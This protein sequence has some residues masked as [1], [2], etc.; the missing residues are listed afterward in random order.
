MGYE[1][2]TILRGYKTNK[3]DIVQEFYLPVLKESVLYKRAVGFFSSTALIELSKGI[4]GLVK[5]GGKIRFIVSPLLSEEDIE[6]IQKGYEARTIIESALVREIKEPQSDSD[7][8]RL[9]WLSQLIANGV[10][11]IKVAFTPPHKAT[12]MYHEKI[13]VIY[14]GNGNLI[15]FTGSMNETINA[16]H[17]NYE[18]IVVFNSLVQEDK[19]RV[20]DLENDFDSLWASREENITV[21]EFPKVVRDRLVPYE[22]YRLS[23]HDNDHFEAEDAYELSPVVAGVPAIPKGVTLHEYQNDAISAW[24][25]NGMRG[26]F[27][28]ATGTGKTYTGLGAVVKAFE[29]NK[30]LAVII[31]AP[32][33]HL[34]DQWVEDIVK[35][36]MRPTI[37]YSASPQ[38]DWKRRLGND[39][40]DFELGCI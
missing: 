6:A 22:K 14:D 4:A 8:E 1:H 32:Y 27:D 5:N 29:L 17:N 30:R 39:V 16:F 9:G 10:L 40:L 21:L 28:M 26:I 3:N 2:L 37:G 11:E 7:K 33:Q 15:A 36:N 34:V 19:Q 23:D 25:K 20:R 31:V 18:S 12:G 35:F 38:K 13:G 24:I